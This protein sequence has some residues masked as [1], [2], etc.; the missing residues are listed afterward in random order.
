MV[1]FEYVSI[2]GAGRS[3]TTLLMSMLHAHSKVAFPPESHFLRNYLSRTVVLQ[4]RALREALAKD[5][6]FGR[7]GVTIDEAVG[8]PR[9]PGGEVDL[10]DVYRRILSRHGK[11][12]GATHVGDKD[13]KNVEHLQLIKAI[14]DRPFVIHLIRD[15]RDVYLS[16]EQADWAK[17][18]SRVGHLLAYRAHLELGMKG[19]KLFGDRYLA[20]RFEDLVTD[21]ESSLR[22]LCVGLNLPFEP[23]MLDHEQSARELVAEDEMQWKSTALKPI[24]R[25]NAEKWKRSKL[26]RKVLLAIESACSPAFAGRLY[27]KSV[28]PS[29]ILER[30]AAFGWELG[31]GLLSTLYKWKVERD[32]R[33]VVNRLRKRE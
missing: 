14:F 15:P 32:E 8:E 9:E 1:P 6:Y 29:T 12:K 30:S 17:G 4:R 5:A 21:P 23:Q 28:E 22:R 7:L 24:I 11:L 2:V 20:V 31:V 19:E 16:R 3:G 33:G 10:V 26:D 13:P 27:D 18:R 25:A